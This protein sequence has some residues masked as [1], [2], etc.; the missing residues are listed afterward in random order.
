VARGIELLVRIA[1]DAARAG[2]DIDRAG[3]AAERFGAGVKTMAVPAAVAGAAVAA[4]GKTAIDAASAAQQAVGGVEA[5]FGASAAQVV[6]WSEDAVN[7]A[8]L[9]A[10]AYDTM[11]AGIGGALT[12]MGVPMDAAAQSTQDLIT[13]SA[14]LASVFG[15][16]T[17]QAADA[18]TSAFRGE[19]DSLQRLIPG[20]SAAAVEAEMTAEASAG[21]TFASQDAAKAH[22]ITA[23]IMDKSAA[24]AGNFAKEADTAEGASARAGATAENTAATLGQSLLPAYTALQGVLQG[25]ATWVGQNSTLVLVLAGVIGGLAAAVLIVNGVMAVASA[26]TAAWAAIQAVASGITTGF[27]AV[28]GALNA[29]MSANPVMIVVIAVI[30]LIAGIILLWNN[31]EAFRTFILSM[32][33]AIASAATAAW[34][35]ISNAASAAWNAISSLVGSVI[36]SISSAVS[37]AGNLISN[38]WNS[39]RSAAAS[40]WNAIGS[41]V[42]SVVSG[43]SSAVSGIVGGIVSA[44]NSIQSAASSAWNAISSTVSSVTSGIS[45]FV[46]SMSSAIQSVFNAIMAAGQRIWGPIQSAA[47]SALNGIKSIIDSVMGAINGVIGGIQ[48]A[49]SFVSDLW[50]KITGASSAAASIPVPAGVTSSSYGFA[51]AS[52]SL[53]RAGLLAAPRAAAGTTS[54]GGVSIVVNGALDPDAVARQ[55]E[56]ILRGRGRRSG[57]TVL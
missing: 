32:W 14:D 46:N 33:A 6:A 9:S 18:V 10:S 44:W 55:I 43:V 16:T 30:A 48:K 22:A 2:E 40:V 37:S 26:A 34:T 45:G 53:G 23:V 39:I 51:A 20:M 54:P 42:S 15:G 8:G 49:A 27:T 24:A 38:V 13:R 47:S 35:V 4:F 7:S 1:V 5:V 12:G 28:M 29:V 36:S 17:A 31:C 11:A 52:P 56:N 3:S 41:L 57:G 25:V 50:G 19:Y 21:M